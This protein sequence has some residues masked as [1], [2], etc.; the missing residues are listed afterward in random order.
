MVDRLVPDQTM[1]AGQGIVANDGRSWLTMQGDGNLVLYDK[2]SGRARAV[3]ASNTAGHPGARAAMQG[4][5]NLVVYAAGGQPLWASNTA[6]NP[7]AVLVMQDDANAVV[8][9]PDGRPLWASNTMR[10]PVPID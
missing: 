6:G 4:D 7:G 1:A 8:Y 5:G 9:A 2:F 10:R 3:W